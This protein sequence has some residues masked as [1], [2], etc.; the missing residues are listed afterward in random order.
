MGDERIPTIRLALGDD[1]STV[2]RQSTYRFARTNL[3]KIDAIMANTP[4]IFEYTRP[5]CGFSLPP[6]LSFGASVDNWHVTG[7]NVS[8]H[9]RY[10]SENTALDLTG[11]QL[12][13]LL[14]KSGWERT[15]RYISLDSIQKE[16]ADPQ[17]EGDHTIRI[18]DW[19]CGDDKLYV[20]VERHWKSGESLPRL[21]GDSQDL[22][23]VTVKI[24]N[25][26]VSA[27]YPGR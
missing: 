4:F 1:L 25:D 23:V 13:T 18:E 19:G 22:Y 7:V 5:G 17:T 8:P 9:L 16:F 26:K 14:Q 10:I 24:R 27:L 21:A 15:K 11:N 2:Q 6:G 20:E 12:V 3:A